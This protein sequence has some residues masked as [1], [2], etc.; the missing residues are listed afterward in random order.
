MAGVNLGFMEKNGGGFPKFGQI[1]RH[2]NFLGRIFFLESQML[3]PCCPPTFLGQHGFF[4]SP[5]EKQQIASKKNMMSYNMRK[6]KKDQVKTSGG[7]A[8]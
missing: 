3:D 1:G 5:K 6:N 4:V 7:G 8:N 2:G